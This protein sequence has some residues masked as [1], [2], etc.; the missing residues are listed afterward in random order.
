[1]KV[2]FDTNVYVS[3]TLRRSGGAQQ[4]LAGTR[5]LR[6]RVF[7]SDYVLTEIV[8]TLQD[9]LAL[10]ARIAA[11]ARDRAADQATSVADRPSPHRVPGDAKD[12]PILAAALAC[13]ADYLVTN[14]SHLLDLN[15]Y[16]GL[17][18]V[19]VA[20]YREILRAHGP[21]V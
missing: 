19:T 13:G 4:V 18:I 3:A 5:G 1:M 20:P 21:A 15:P 14:D 7:V 16:E 9:R 12:S 17:R 6:W 8:T 11:A 2:F 10:S